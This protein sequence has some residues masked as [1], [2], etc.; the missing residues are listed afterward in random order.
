MPHAETKD[1]V[2]IAYTDAG[3]SDTACL[4]MPGWCIERTIFDPLIARAGK[5]RR[6]IALDWRGHGESGPS[7]GD[8]GASEL[9][10]DALAVVAASGVKRVIPVA[11]AHAGWIAIDLAR[12]LGDRVPGLVL[13]SWMLFAPPPPFA[14]MLAALQEETR[15][16]EARE[17]L[18]GMWLAGGP[19]HVVDAI[20]SMTARYGPAMWAR[21]ACAIAAAFAREGTAAEALSRLVPLRPTL[22]LY[23]Q[24]RAPE[25]LAA[26]EAF[27]RDHSFFHFQRVEGATHFPTLEAPDAWCSLPSTRSVAEGAAMPVGA[28]YKQHPPHGEHDAIVIGSGMGGLASAA[29]LARYGKRRVL[30]LERHY[31]A[32][33]TR[34]RS[35]GPATSGTS[36]CTTSVRSASAAP[37]PDVRLPHRRQARWA[38]LP[39]VYDRDLPRRSLVRLSS[40]ARVASS[41]R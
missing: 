40:P 35:R 28:S 18:V 14:D 5:G 36:A 12:R 39:D 16:A 33:A 11:Q 4:C 7:E 38:P 9:L 21:A 10:E 3:S 25:Y 23:A 29:A 1:G 15:F 32:A 31:R 24:P 13:T 26:H 41:R 22:H 30:V 6:V 37:A 8:F 20:R 17:K 2:S 27:A 19:P 34:T